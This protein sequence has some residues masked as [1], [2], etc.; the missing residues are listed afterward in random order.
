MEIREERE[1]A[2]VVLHPEGKLDVAAAADFQLRA[3]K[4]VE[5]GERR[6]IVDLAQANEVCGAALRVLLTLAKRLNG[7]G[8]GLAVCG[9]GEEARRALEVAGLAGAFPVFP[10]RPT[11]HAWVGKVGGEKQRVEQVTEL[12]A[13]LLGAATPREPKPTKAAK[14]PAS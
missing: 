14:K 1:G 5:G 2:V 9:M 4:L 3:A 7:L 13:R 6:M 8:G 12:A 10:D 11:A